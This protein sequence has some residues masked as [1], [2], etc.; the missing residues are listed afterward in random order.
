[1]L[2]MAWLR[3]AYKASAACLCSLWMASVSALA[4]KA[5]GGGWEGE[6][7]HRTNQPSRKV[8]GEKMPRRGRGV[9]GWWSLWMLQTVPWPAIVQGVGWD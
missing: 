5:S 2:V 8:W 3:A 4:C 9:V 6:L 1:M 7:K